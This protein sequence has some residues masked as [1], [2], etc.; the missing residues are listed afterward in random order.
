MKRFTRPFILASLMT[1]SSVF[2]AFGQAITIESDDMPVPTEPYNIDD[3]GNILP[4]ASPIE[5]GV[6]DYENAHAGNYTVAE[7][8]PETIPF[9]T[10]AGVDAYRFLLKNLN[11]GFG[12]NL[13][14]E[15][16]FNTGSIDDI[17]VDVPGQAYTLQPFTGNINDS[18]FFPAQR[19]IIDTPRRIVE[20]P[21]TMGS[22]WSSSSRRVTD[23]VFNIPAFGLNYQTVQHAYTWVRQDTVVGWGKMRVYTPDGP[24]IYY[25]VLMDKISEFT[26]DSFYMNGLPA[27]APLLSAFGVAQGQKTEETYRYNFYRKGSFNYLASFFYNTDATFSTLAGIFFHLDDL[28]TAPSA[29]TSQKVSYATILYPNPSRGSEINI[30]VMGND[31]TFSSYFITDAQGKTVQEGEMDNIGGDE[32]RVYMNEVLPAGNYYI[33][34][35]DGK[36]NNIIS[37]Q[38]EVIN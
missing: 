33:T 12:Y 2:T 15:F 1:V 13:Y 30:K 27:P 6:W 25:D 24:S 31:L 29:T 9:F 3:V 26:R 16:D 19:Y 22:A 14:M 23:M 8:Y 18:I 20:F 17:A 4:N 36:R 11:T 10:D 34:L 21:M 32:V 35:R 38:F 5:N 7:F 37:E 28:E